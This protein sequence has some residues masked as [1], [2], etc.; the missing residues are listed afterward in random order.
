NCLNGLFNGIFGEESLA[1]ALTRRQDGGAVAAWA[2]SSATPPAVQSVVN[3]ELFRLIFS[4]TYKTAGEAVAAAKRVVTNQDL[5]RSWIFFG[6][7]AMQ[8]S[9]APQPTSVTAPAVTT[10]PQSAQIVSGQQ[11]TLTVAATGAR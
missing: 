2:S 8:L 1:E 10:H 9:G 6:D 5:R 3:Q 11:T 7:P 4:G